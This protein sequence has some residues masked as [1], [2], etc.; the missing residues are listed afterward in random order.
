MRFHP[1]TARLRDRLNRRMRSVTRTGRAE[2]TTIVDT[3]AGSFALPKNVARGLAALPRWELVVDLVR[4]HLIAPEA[5]IAIHGV[6]I[7]VKMFSVLIEAAGRPIPVRELYEKV[8]GMRWVSPRCHTAAVH[9]TVFRARKLLAQV[10]QQDRLTASPGTGY[11]FYLGRSV[12]ALRNPARR[13]AA[14]PPSGDASPILAILRERG[15]VDNRE[16]RKRA[17]RSRATMYRELR[18]LV[19]AGTLK[20]V[21]KGRAARYEPASPAEGFLESGSIVRTP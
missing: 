11:A 19:A 10:G 14:P 8:W 3:A 18:R 16:L 9:V 6:E 5:S 21:G 12:V 17:G 4:G 2:G 1:E 20:M 15:Y 7:V 13:R